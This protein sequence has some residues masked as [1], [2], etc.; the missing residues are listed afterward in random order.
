[1]A[2]PGEW[3]ISKVSLETRKAIKRY[4]LDHDM[5]VGEAIESIVADYMEMVDLNRKV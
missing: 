2:R 4:A 1:M 5:T 3:H